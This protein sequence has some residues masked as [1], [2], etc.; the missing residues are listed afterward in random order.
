MN[1]EEGGRNDT[2]PVGQYSPEGDSP[3]KASDMAGNVLEWCADW[4]NE[5]EYQGRKSSTLKNPQG[6]EKGEYRVL[7]D[8]SFANYRGFA[9]CAGRHRDGPGVT[10]RDIG[11][12]VVVSLF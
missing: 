6:P 7:R 12:R 1:S 2:T 5:K 3:Y 11:F 8:G 4:F 9:R 10:F